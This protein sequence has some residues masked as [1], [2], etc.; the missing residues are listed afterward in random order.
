MKGKI[1]GFDAA[2]GTGAI[3]GEDGQRYSFA[4]ADFKSPAPAKPGDNVDF[5][6][7]GSNAK[8]IYV[9]AGAMP[10]VDLAAL[11]SN[12]TVAN[13]LAKPYVIWAAVII[14]GSLIAGYFG[15]LGML[16][17]MSGPFGSGLGLAALIAALLFFVPIVAGVLIFFEFTNNKL[18]GQFRLITAAVAI[19][20]PI[21][22]PVLAGLLAPQGFQDIM[23]MASSFGGG[24]S[25]YAGFIGFGITP[26]MVITVA[27]G[28]LIVLSHLGIIKKLG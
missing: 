15:A 4:A 16:N 21:L 3:S 10:N 8:E 26:G 27:G 2:G 23:S 6:V 14:L 11:T 18:T 20:G 17:S 7:D 28:V 19:G 5:A 12:A 13:I 24:G 22:L 1:L 9:T 25:P